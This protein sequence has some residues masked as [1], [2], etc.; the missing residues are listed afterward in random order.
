[1]PTIKEVLKYIHTD[2][3]DLE[4]NLR[5]ELKRVVSVLINL[6]IGGVKVDA[7]AKDIVTEA[8]AYM[9]AVT[10]IV[11]TCRE[12]PGTVS[13]IQSWVYSNPSVPTECTLLSHMTELC[14]LTRMY[15]ISTGGDRSLLPTICTEEDLNEQCVTRC[16]EGGPWRDTLFCELCSGR[17][18][19][20]WITRMKMSKTVERDTMEYNVFIKMVIMMGSL[21]TRQKVLDGKESALYDAIYAPS[22]ESLP[23]GKE[24]REFAASLIDR[25][26]SVCKGDPN[27]CAY[28]EEVKLRN[29]RVNTIGD[30]RTVLGRITFVVGYREM[31]SSRAIHALLALLLIDKAIFQRLMYKVFET[32]PLSWA[33]LD[34]VFGIFEG[35]RATKFF[36]QYIHKYSLDLGFTI[37]EPLAS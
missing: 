10:K 21:I 37:F 12:R 13:Y 7:E 28:I 23:A 27:V 22:A 1:V 11:N 36:L 4:A 3:K 33:D 19:A 24:H 14:R 6:G 5:G 34:E 35:G 17:R 16:G 25:Y 30:L 31:E 29:A 9:H 18:A 2:P 8:I 32:K 26:L 20:R 15:L